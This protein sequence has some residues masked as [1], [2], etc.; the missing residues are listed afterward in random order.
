MDWVNAVREKGLK[1]FYIYS[2]TAVCYFARHFWDISTPEFRR[3]KK[4][5]EETLGE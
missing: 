4:L 2:S 3:V 1:N 5:I